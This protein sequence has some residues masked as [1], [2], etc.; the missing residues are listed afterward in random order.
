MTYYIIALSEKNK[1]SNNKLEL[2]VK[3]PSLMHEWAKKEDL[4]DFEYAYNDILLTL[5]FLNEKFLTNHSYI[6]DKLD[7]NSINVFRIKDIV[8]DKCGNQFK[9]RYDEMTADDYKTH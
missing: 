4:N 6:Y 1:N 8:T 9:K 7:I 2:S 5:E 3:I